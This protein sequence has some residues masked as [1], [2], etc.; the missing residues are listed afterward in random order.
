MSRSRSYR[1]L[2]SFAD[3]RTNKALQNNSDAFYNYFERLMNM[4]LVSIKYENL[5]ET[6]DARFLNLCLLTQGSFLVFNDDEIGI[7]ATRWT[8]SGNFDI[9][10]TPI[11]REAYTV[12]QKAYHNHLT[13]KDSVIVYDNYLRT[14]AIYQLMRYAE[15]LANLDRI[16]DVNA[17]LLKYGAVIQCQ[18]SQR[19]T[20]ENLMMQYS[21]DVP[22]IFADKDLDLSGINVIK[23]DIE[24]NTMELQALKKEIWTEALNYIGIEAFSSDKKERVV[25]GET[26]GND[27]NVE[28]CRNTRM[29]M[30]TECWDKVN[31]MFGT[32]VVPVWNSDMHS[33]INTPEDFDIGGARL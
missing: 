7:I 26:T 22:L 16:I 13:D 29:L 2:K 15:R 18:E 3:S 25:S 4:W 1:C 9:Y 27:G 12:N 10:D 5:P 28:A 33:A 24:N 19:M 6:M 20:M 31:K 32:E 14:P 17:N 23:F 30:S 11:G 21:G 8:T